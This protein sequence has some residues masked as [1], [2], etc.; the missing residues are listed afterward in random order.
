M[1]N[2]S[3]VVSGERIFRKNPVRTAVSSL[4]FSVLLSTAAL[5]IVPQFLPYLMDRPTRGLIVGLIAIA[6]TIAVW[7][8]AFWFRNMR[9]VVGPDAVEIGRP[10]SRETYSRATT[11]FRSKITEHRT[12]GLRSGTTRALVVHSAGREIAVELPGFTRAT[13]NEL[14]AAL[15]PIAASH[16][17][18]V[19]AARERA[20][21][22][23]TFT[24]DAS[25]ERR[26]ASRLT[27]VAVVALVVTV[28]VVLLA[29]TP[30]F[31][32]GELSALILLAPIAAVIGIGFAIGAMQR[33][34]VAR[35]APTQVSLSHH[36]IRIGEVDHVYAQ[37]T[38]IWVTPP[39]YPVA[40]IRIDRA[41]ARSVTHT[42]VSSRIAMTPEYPVFLAA[43][44]AQTAGVPGLLS[45][46]LE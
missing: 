27:I 25:G 21:L 9:V 10:G 5:F 32:D 41:G 4:V 23:D 45:L 39:A 8:G 11:A 42:L 6:L 30:G 24:I 19:S 18:P 46:D 2:Q 15:N 34:R 26:F 16:T 44:Q 22:P 28:A 20:S 13:F 35:S 3:Q 38:R 40:R 33:Y 1:V 36:G 29:L 31:L 7:T 43:L 12:N 17:D 37:L 14:M